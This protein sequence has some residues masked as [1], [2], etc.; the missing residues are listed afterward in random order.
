[1]E[2]AWTDHEWKILGSDTTATQL[3]ANFFYLTNNPRILS[4]LVHETRTTFSD[5]EE[6]RVGD[7]LSSCV[8]LSAVIEE[9]LRINPSV[10]GILPRE[11]LPGGITVCDEF[12]PAGVELS[13]PI[14]TLHHNP[15]YYPEPHKYVPER[16]LAKEN[17]EESL[18]LAA[19]ACNPFSYGSRICVGWKLAKMELHL[20][21]ARALY[22]YDIE[23]IGGGRED[24]LG[25]DVMEYKL[26]DHLAA[27]RSGPIILFK[28]A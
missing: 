26:M 11:V 3:A 8:Y 13:V 9:T 16:W 6:I 7:K 18:K 27:G 23:Y 17:D 15:N 28:K 25:S 24:R 10:P 4:K 2:I 12:F 19:D 21:L 22:L 20:V 5:V 14:Y 1:M